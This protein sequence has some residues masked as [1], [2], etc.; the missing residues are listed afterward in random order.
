MTSFQPAV[1]A[2]GYQSIS[3]KLEKATAFKLQGNELFKEGKYKKALI[4]YA[5]VLAFTRG[6]PGKATMAL[7][8]L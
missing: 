6:L 2:G 1:P 7:G 4:A 8:G 3:E 5:K